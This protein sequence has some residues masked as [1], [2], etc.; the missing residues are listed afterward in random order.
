MIRKFI[1]FLTKPEPR[2][3]LGRW[4]VKSCNELLTSINSVY[5]NRD[6]FCIPRGRF[7]F[8]DY[9]VRIDF[10]TSYSNIVPIHQRSYRDHR[11]YV[12]SFLILVPF[13]VVFYVKT[14]CIPVDRIFYNGF[15]VSL[16]RLSFF[17]LFF[18]H[19]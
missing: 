19:D 2:P 6:H 17:S 18:S 14:I 16:C 3:V 9:Y 12:N 4:A 10:Q 7:D 5:Q 11:V 15:V 13:F 1:D 8:K